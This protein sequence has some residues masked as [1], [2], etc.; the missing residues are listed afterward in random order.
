MSFCCCE[1]FWHPAKMTGKQ[2]KHFIFTTC[3]NMKCTL[4]FLLYQ[5]HHMTELSGKKWIFLYLVQCCSVNVVFVFYSYF[6]IKRNAMQVIFVFSRNFH[7]N[8]QFL[9]TYLCNIYKC[10]K[11]NSGNHVLYDGSSLAAHT[12]TSSR[13]LPPAKI[14][15]FSHTSFTICSRSLV[16][17]SS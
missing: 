15:A 11:F 1:Q 6:N 13:W 2:N 8:R 14:A 5:L 4:K 10:K 17:S 7:R 12:V 9:C 16:L 3:R